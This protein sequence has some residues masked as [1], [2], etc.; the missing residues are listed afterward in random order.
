[1][2]AYET[3][4]IEATNTISDAAKIARAVI[5]TGALPDLPAWRISNAFRFAW[6]RV[7]QIIREAFGLG[8]SCDWGHVELAIDKRLRPQVWNRPEDEITIDCRAVAEVRAEREAE[9]ASERDASARQ[10]ATADQGDD[11]AAWGRRVRGE[12]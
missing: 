9:A 3:D 11:L 1:M 5:E 6:G 7:P 12:N 4:H 2:S 8:E 10:I